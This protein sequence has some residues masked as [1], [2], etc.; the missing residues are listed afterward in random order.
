MSSTSVSVLMPLI[1]S[2]SPPIAARQAIERFLASTGLQFEILPIAEA[3]YGAAVRRGVSE[4][5]GDIVVVADPELPYP[6]GA[7]GDAVAM[8]D[9]GATDIVFATTHHNDDDT[10]HPLLRWFLVPV[11]PDPAIRLKAFSASAAKFV[12]GES[13][14]TGGGCELEIAFLANKYGFRVEPIQVHCDSKQMPERTFGG[15]SGL[16]SLIAIRMNDRRMHYRAARRCPVCFSNEVWSWAQIPG[17]IVRACHRCKCRYLNRFDPDEEGLPVHR[18][19]RA[20]TPAGDALD[21]TVHSRNAREK[22]SLRRLANVRRDIP[23][24]ARLLEVGVRDASFAAAASRDYEYVGIDHASA[25][26]R[27]ARARGLEVY[28][29]ALQNFVNTGPAF[30]AI[31]MFHV[32]ENMSDPHDALGRVKDLLKPGGTLFLTTFDTEGFLYLLT[33]RKRMMH[34][35][36]TH[37]ILYSRSALIELLEHSGFEIQSIVPDF[38]YRDHKFLRHWLTTRLPRLGAI[39]RAILPMLPDP[40]LVTS[41]SIRVIARRRAGAPI[42]VRAI[43]SVEP[44]HAR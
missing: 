18:E 8:I 27:A 38:E 10:R 2:G 1:G 43:R 19:L 34:N 26:A 22:T 28:C 24:R 21:D 36:R 41:G 44:T 17:N 11:L 35:F 15:V 31:A 16:P 7:I 30:D 32:F 5:K 33:E 14:L 29:A 42:N 40:L 37:L 20:Y 12:V 23:Q 25:A 39:A 9:S 6:V 13:K 4:A 3:T